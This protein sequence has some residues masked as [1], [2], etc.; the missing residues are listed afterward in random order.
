MDGSL[1]TEK[2][3][4]EQLS[5][6]SPLQA[7]VARDI[8]ALVRRDGLAVGERLVEAR[9]AGMIGTSRS[10][11]TA[12]LHF[13]AGLGVLAHDHNRGHSLAVD[14]ESLAP[15][16]AALSQRSEEPLYLLLAEDRLG[17][18]LPEECSESELMRR[19]NVARGSL[20]ETL[21]RLHDEGWAERSVGTGWRFLPLIDTRE[22]Y[23]ESYAFRSIIEPAALLL[24]SFRLDLEALHELRLR[25]TF[26]V[27]G[28]WQT[29]TSF[30][31]FEANRE[32]H[33]GLAALSG[34]RFILQSLRRIDA[35]RRLQEYRQA[36]DREA[37]KGQSH[38]HLAILEVL[39]AGDKEKA[40]ALL[41]THLEGARRSKAAEK[42]GARAESNS[43]TVM[44]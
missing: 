26:I 38:E 39:E 20:R 22:A 4:G 16:A 40:S 29:M 43:S 36:R 33:E 11:V 42:G 7:R 27:E 44:S 30:E 23:E 19:Y 37:R 14:A 25:Q 24:P 34:N 13:L 6:L 18:S 35:Q 32:F 5:A 2:E 28:G 21:A 10:P 8:V 31:L 1:M 9:L 41:A 3:V 12:A 17:G 15:L